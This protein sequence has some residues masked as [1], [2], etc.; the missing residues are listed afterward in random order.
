V[1][2]P[3]SRERLSIDEN[4]LAHYALKKPDRHGRKDLLFHPHELLARMTAQIPAPRLCLRRVFGVLAPRSP[5]REKVVAPRTKTVPPVP[6]SGAVAAEVPTPPTRTPWEELLRQAFQSDPTRCR[7]GGTLRVVAVVRC[8]KQA[9][10]YLAGMGLYS[11]LPGER[12]GP[13]TRAP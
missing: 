8:R 9:R 3:L 2:P 4:G 1:R 11:R 6:R 10:R 5:L 13:R 12:L 7:C